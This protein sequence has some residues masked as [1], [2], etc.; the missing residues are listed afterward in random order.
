MR[1]LL[2]TLLVPGLILCAP[3]NDRWEIIAPG[4]DASQFYPT[5]TPHNPNPAP[6]PSPPPLR[7]S[8]ATGAPW[9]AERAFPNPIR[10][11]W[12][13]P[14]ALYVTSDRT[15]DIR[16]K[17]VWRETVPAP[18]PWVDIAVAS[19]VLY[20][21][22]ENSGAV[23]EDA[24]K[25]WRTFELPGIGAR[26]HAIA[27]SL[28]HPDTAYLSYDSLRLDGQIWFGVAKTTDWGRTWRLVWKEGDQAAPNVHDAWLTPRFGPGWSGRPLH[29]DVAPAHPNIS[30]ATH[31]HPP[32][33]TSIAAKTA[34]PFH[35][36][37]T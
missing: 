35:S 36:P 15:L 26:F 12:A 3:R 5:A 34:R 11:I 1:K 17:G 16:E 22:S 21:V 25:S 30:S 18:A 32:P 10:P 28:H 24:G 4:G 20:A 27:T 9:G 6:P 31:M 2:P 37:P 29:L 7:I 23:S 8:E 13:A 33:P 19:P 14:D